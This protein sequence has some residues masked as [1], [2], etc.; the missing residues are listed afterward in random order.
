MW[1]VKTVVSMVLWSRTLPAWE[2]TS[3][4]SSLAGLFLG[5]I[6][7]VFCGARE[8]GGRHVISVEEVEAVSD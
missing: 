1:M 5:G 3:T 4:G 7:L 2:G 6:S 8:H